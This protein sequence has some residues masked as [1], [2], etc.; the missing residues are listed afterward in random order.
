MHFTWRDGKCKA[1]RAAVAFFVLCAALATVNWAFAQGQPAPIG[2]IQQDETLPNIV[3]IVADDFGYGDL[4]CYGASKIITPHVDGLASNGIRFA[5]AYVGSS[6]CSPS[7]YSI[8]TGRYSW[9]TQLKKGVLTPFA[10][11]LIEENRT[12]LAAILKRKGYFN[13]CVGKWHLGFNWP[14]KNNAPPDAVETVFNSWGTDPQD[15]IDFSKPVRGGPLEKGFDYFFG[16]SGSNNMVPFVFLENN[17]VLAPPSVPNNFG[18]KTLRAPDWDLRA[19]DQKL[20]DKAVEVI[21]RHFVKDE[22]PLFLYFPTSAI[23]APCL[24]MATSGSSQAGVRG[25]KVVEFDQMVGEV[26]KALA[27]NGVLEN[28]MIIITS[29]NG[30]QPGDP[31]SLVQRLKTKSLGSEYDY[32]QPYFSE[33]EAAFPGISGQEN[34]W[35]TYHHSPTAGLLGFKS[36]AWDGGLRVPLIVHWPARIKQ[37]S[38]NANMISTVDLFATMA[39]VTGATLN[40]NEGED[41]YSFLPCLLDRNAHQVRKS[42]TMVAGRSGALIIRKGDWKYIEAALPENSTSPSA[43]PPPPNEYPGVPGAFEEQLYNLKRDAFERRNLANEF[44]EK[45]GELKVAIEH[46]KANVKG[47]GK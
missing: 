43:Y 22:S 26:V 31:Y 32:Y 30:P 27:R 6:L 2:N 25:D 41:S 24:P 19:L 34:G 9:R 42:L 3:L 45:V 18:P 10:P 5:N 44:P 40:G 28:T 37:A 36:D 1:Y 13:A 38:V 15:Y 33:Y 7:R 17:K 35:L 8:L 29:D 21:D 47:E 20:T 14:L 4:S 11:P 16:I 39:E 46:V 12:T 23:H